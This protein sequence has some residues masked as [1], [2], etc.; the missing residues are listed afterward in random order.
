MK[1]LKEILNGKV[2]TSLCAFVASFAT[3][4][5]VTDILLW[6]KYGLFARDIWEVALIGI[7]FFI[8]SIYFFYKLNKK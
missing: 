1:K 7:V 8:D 2:A 3:G 6:K 5:T 4:I